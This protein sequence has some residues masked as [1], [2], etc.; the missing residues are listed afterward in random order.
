MKADIFQKRELRDK[1]R[2]FR[3]RRVA[4]QVLGQMLR[5]SYG[6]DDR[7]VVLAIPAG[8]VPVALEVS[9]AL[10]SPLDLIIAKKL[11]IPQNPEAGYGAITLEGGRFLNETLVSRFNISP[12]AI[13]AHVSR[14]KRELEERDRLFRG[15][16]PSPDLTHGTAILVDDGLASGYTMM[17]SI[18]AA[19]K[20]RAEKIVV[21]VPTG[22][23]G[24]IKRIWERV[25]EIYCP[26]IR[27]RLYFA[28][29]DAY[30]AW[31]DLG[32]DEVIRLME[33]ARQGR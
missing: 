30:E 11:P 28:V 7:A 32:S 27:D 21:A 25:D 12:D 10:D 1:N 19:K 22:P 15:D 4:G 17:A 8:G 13:E 16:R 20:R 6:R 2:V 3:D 9:K 5:S 31:Y 23:M 29:A 24:S 14:I 33:E 18:E 26:N